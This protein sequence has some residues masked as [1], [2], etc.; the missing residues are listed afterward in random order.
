MDLNKLGI[1]L[2]TKKIQLIEIINFDEEFT[3]QNIAEVYFDEE[4][5]FTDYKE[6]KNLE[7]IQA[8]YNEIVFNTKIKATNT[9]ITLPIELFKVFQVPIDNSLLY[10]DQIHQLKW[11]YT[12]LFPMDE[13]D[14]VVLQFYEVAKNSIIPYSS[15]IVVSTRRKY[16]KLLNNFCLKNFLNL[17]HIDNAHFASDKAIEIVDSLSERSLVLSL[18]YLNNYLSIEILFFGKPIF[19]KIFRIKNVNDIPEVLTQEVLNNLRI[20]GNRQIEVAYFIG[21]ELSHN[22]VNE[23]QMRLNINFRINN[24]FANLQIEN[25][26]RTN[27]LFLEKYNS[28]SA[29]TGIALRLS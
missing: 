29:A 22:L 4:I 23:I 6:T 17:V 27:K 15:A 5:N 19:I 12:K 2:T 3:L 11:E 16:L 8:A 26:I 1:N 18:Y 25:S 21:E 24:P 20:V 10:Q 14:E 9:S 13:V 28:F 7:I